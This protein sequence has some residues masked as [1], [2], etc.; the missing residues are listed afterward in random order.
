[1]MVGV[2][3]ELDEADMGSENCWLFCQCDISIS[4]H[5]NITKKPPLTELLI[6][7]KL[8]HK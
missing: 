3:G 7:V 1:M 2:V 5:V 8:K 4:Y 6:F